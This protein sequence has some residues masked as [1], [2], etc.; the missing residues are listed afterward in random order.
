MADRT[1][2]PS[3]KNLADAET[4]LEGDPTFRALTKAEQQAL[5]EQRAHELAQLDRDVPGPR[6]TP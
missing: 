3:E 5:V 4:D 2:A 1:R 6:R